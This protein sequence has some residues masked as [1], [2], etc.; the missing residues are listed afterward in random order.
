MF[1]SRISAKRMFRVYNQT[2]IVP[3]IPFWPFVHAPTFLS[4][5]YDYFQPCSGTFPNAR[6]HSAS[7]YAGYMRRAKIWSNARTRRAIPLDE[8]HILAWLKK[9]GPV[10][11]SFTELEM[12]DKAI[13]L[14]I[15]R[16]LKIIG[17]GM[18]A[19]SSGTFTIVDKLA[20]ILKKGIDVSKD[21][22][23][24][25]LSLV[26]KILRIL[27]MNNILQAVEATQMYIRNLL[28]KL[29]SRISLECQK[30][31]NEALIQGRQVY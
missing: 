1:T 23:G 18:T 20:Y 7:L 17:S 31:L 4:D 26:K 27:G 10:S 16:S 6:T 2:D 12:L 13:N 28:M 21:M 15:Q 25:V 19:L 9:D 5:T 11:F 30:I 3:C 8:T 24:I 29:Y 14:V 22:S